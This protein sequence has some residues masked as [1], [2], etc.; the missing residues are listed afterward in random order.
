MGKERLATCADGPIHVAHVLNA[1]S[2]CSSAFAIALSTFNLGSIL[3]LR[4][5]GYLTS[6]STNNRELTEVRGLASYNKGRAS[7]TGSSSHADVH[8]TGAA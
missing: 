3:E 7:G 4:R 2:R 5:R 8:R 1:C 6:E